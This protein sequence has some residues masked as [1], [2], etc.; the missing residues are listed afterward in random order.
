[1][2]RITELS[3]PLDS[4]HHALRRAILRRL[5]IND[6]DLLDFSVVAVT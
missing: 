5:Q 4:D 3:L 1:M 2:L 6:A